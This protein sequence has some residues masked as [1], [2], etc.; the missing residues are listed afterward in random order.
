MINSFMK[1]NLY[2]NDKLYK[3]VTVQGNS[4]KHSEYIA[5][6]QEDQKSGLLQKYD[7]GPDDQLKIR[8]EKSN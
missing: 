1:I 3:T 2:V 8:V 5:H 6:I 7:I 4:Y